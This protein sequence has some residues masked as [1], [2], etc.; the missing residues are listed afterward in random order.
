MYLTSRPLGS[1]T[2]L[3]PTGELTVATA[4]G[5][6]RQ[7][8]L[9]LAPAAEPLVAVDLA[10]V[11]RIDSSGYAALV[12]LTRQV[13][14]RRGNLCLVG[15][16][17]EARLLLEIMQLHLVFDVCQDMPAAVEALTVTHEPAPAGPRP[18]LGR[19]RFR[20]PLLERRAS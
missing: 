8:R 2:V 12:A 14:R 5:F 9:L 3:A 16:A 1:V 17:A 4:P 18:L 13:Q 6:L 20:R 11:R 15:L 19:V 10:G 7:A